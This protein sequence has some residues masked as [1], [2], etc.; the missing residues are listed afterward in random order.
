MKMQRLFNNTI[1][2][3]LLAV[4][5]VWIVVFILTTG[6]PD[7]SIALSGGKATGES[8]QHIREELQLDQPLSK[9]FFSFWSHLFQGELR[10]YYTSEPLHTVLAAKLNISGILLL[11]ALLSLLLLT[12]IRLAL[13]F[14]FRS[15]NWAISLLIG[16]TSSEPLFISLPIL[17]FLCGRLGISPVIGGGFS[18]AIYPSMLLAT[19]LIDLTGQKK[20]PPQYTILASQCG[21]R[22]PAWLAMKLRAS[23]SAVQIFLNSIAF[24]IL[25]GIPVAELMLGLPGAGRWML[26]SILRIDLPGPSSMLRSNR[27]LINP[28]LRVP[29]HSAQHHFTSCIV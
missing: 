27:R 20:T 9:R 29:L 25:V 18:L 19:N 17:L 1:T 21:L 14:V 12:I 2:H 16:L 3:Y 24:F 23:H 5:V 6:L 10:S 13:M 7:A 11:S 8:L 26:E 4:L 15:S 28:V 22:G